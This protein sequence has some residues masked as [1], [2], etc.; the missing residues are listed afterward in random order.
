MAPP[1]TRRE[2]AVG[3]R[4][5]GD[6]RLDVIEFGPEAIATVDTADPV[7]LG[8]LAQL[9]RNRDLDRDGS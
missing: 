6:V 5:V 3:R 7:E 9:E 8:W 2:V 4:P 1:A